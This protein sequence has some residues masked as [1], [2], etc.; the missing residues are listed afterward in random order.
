[1]T[2]VVLSGFCDVIPVMLIC[3]DACNVDRLLRC[4]TCSIDRLLLSDVFN[5]NRS[6]RCDMWQVLTG[7]TLS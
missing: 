5:A 1:M 6:S 2:P 3:C 4:D 7:D